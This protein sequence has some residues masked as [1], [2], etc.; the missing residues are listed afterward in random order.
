M[1]WLAALLLVLALG[2]D[3]TDDQSDTN[4]LPDTGTVDKYPSFGTGDLVGKRDLLV[5]LP[6]GYAPSG[7]RRYPVLYLHDGQTVFDT[8]AAGIEWGM[9]ETAAALVVDDAIE[10]PI[11]VGISSTSDRIRDYTPTVS[12]LGGGGGL[13]YARFL[14]EEVKPYIDSTYPTLPDRENTSVGGSSLGGLISMA[15]GAWYPELFGGLLVA[16]PSVWW[17]ENVIVSMVRDTAWD[18]R[19][20]IWLDVGTAEGTQAV[21]GA[22]QL[23]DALLEQGWTRDF[24]LAYVEDVGAEHSEVAWAERADDMLQFLYGP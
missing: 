18:V 21:D 1:R 14:V 15:I 24:D 3:A 10:P 7:N 23:R 6:P 5:W 19:P 8:S 2:C 16:S 11:I 17:D 4:Q 22:R 12:D 13:A 9:D 20:R